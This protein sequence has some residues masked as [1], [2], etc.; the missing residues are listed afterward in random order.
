[1]RF[2]QAF[3]MAIK[4]ILNNKMRSI[5]TMLGVIIGVGSVITVVSVIQGTQRKTL[6]MYAQMGTNKIN[7]SYYDWGVDLTDELY[8]YCLSLKDEVDGVTPANQQQLKLRYKTK[9]WTPNVYFGNDKFSTCLNYKLEAGRDI[10]YS[11]IRNRV[12]VCVIGGTVKN[13]F[14][15]LSDPIGKK[16]KISG[17]EFTVVGLY[18]SKAEGQQYSADDMVVVPISSLR[19]LTGSTRVEN[20]I[21]KAKS[22]ETTKSAVKKLETFLKARLSNEWSFNVYS[23]NDWMEQDTKMT[24]MLALVVGGIA[25]ISLVVGGIG[26]MNIMLVSVSERTR[27]IGIRMAIGAPR[28]A[29][30]SQFLIESATISA[31][32]G[33]LGIGLG[34]LGSAIL[35]AAIFKEVYYPTMTIILVAFLFSVS[36]GV[37]FGFYPANKASKM[38]PVDA[39]RNQ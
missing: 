11:D 38:Q 3:S 7:V 21:V 34:A 18:Q 14:F 8:R 20:F 37:F 1:M 25:G 16:I 31:C 17:H 13:E 22:S 4:A 19:T 15:G 39:L 33:V 5:L 23:N 6:E 27:E 30:I 26:I 2:F 29:I 36:L 9:N 32:G 28:R 35:S 12:K 24:D 10:S